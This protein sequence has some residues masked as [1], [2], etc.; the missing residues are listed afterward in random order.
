VDTTKF[1]HSQKSL[2]TAVTRISAYQSCDSPFYTE[3]IIDFIIY[4][5]NSKTINQKL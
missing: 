5:G 4:R 3:H 1:H 2:L